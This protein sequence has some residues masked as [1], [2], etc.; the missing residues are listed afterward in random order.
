MILARIYILCYDTCYGVFYRSNSPSSAVYTHLCERMLRSLGWSWIF[1][2][3]GEWCQYFLCK[4]DIS[5][6][7]RQICVLHPQHWLFVPTSHAKILKCSALQAT[8]E[9]GN[10]AFRTLRDARLRLTKST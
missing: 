7:T 1:G 6:L 10:I 8:A 3:P 2:N 4:I 5:R 9:S